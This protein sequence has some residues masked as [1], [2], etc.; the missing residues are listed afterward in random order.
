MTFGSAGQAS[1]LG[2]IG[3]EELRGMLEL[4]HQNL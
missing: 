3:V 4:L 1:A 2:Q